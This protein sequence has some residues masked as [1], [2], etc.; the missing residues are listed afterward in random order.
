MSTD[1]DDK[2]L[3][4]AETG[5]KLRT[6]PSTLAHWRSKKIGPKYQPVGSRI[7]YRASDVQA[8]LDDMREQ[9]AS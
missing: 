2:L 7:F 1:D 8:Y 9:A 5:K 3:T 6:K 4:P